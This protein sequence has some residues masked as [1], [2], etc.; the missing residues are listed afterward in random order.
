[1]VES[2]A[3]TTSESRAENVAERR[4]FFAVWPDAAVRARLA[5]WAG[6]VRTDPPARRVEAANLHIT[7]VFL[8][9]LDSRQLDAI[10]KVGNDTG[11]TG[12]S[13]TLDRIGF[14]K[15]S[16][17]VWAGSRD[18]CT[19]LSALAEGLRDR[20]R[21]LGFGVEERPFV[22]HVTLYRKAHRKPR[23]AHRCVEWRID[24]F[25]LVESLLT[26]TGAQYS[27]LDRWSADGDM[28]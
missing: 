19:A 11:W 3:G 2:T 27:V 21:R 28:K 25:C 24:D 20:L 15:R 1:M 22:P 14:W 10:R 7:L 26:P 16:R 4:C 5:E 18:G 9:V 12:A 6:E 13:L 17:I 8:G 23:W